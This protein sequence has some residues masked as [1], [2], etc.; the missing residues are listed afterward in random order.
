MNEKTL[1]R[2]QAVRQAGGAPFSPKDT[3]WNW[4]DG[5]VE[6]EGEQA[7]CS[8]GRWRRKDVADR[9]VSWGLLFRDL[10]AYG[11]RLLPTLRADTWYVS[12]LFISLHVFVGSVGH[13][14]TVLE[15]SLPSNY[16]CIGISLVV[17]FFNFFFHLRTWFPFRNRNISGTFLINEERMSCKGL[18]KIM[19]SLFVISRNTLGSLE[20]K[21]TYLIFNT[22]TKILEQNINYLTN[23]LILRKKY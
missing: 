17:I 14:Y 9:A 2:C 12:H 10:Q 15:P 3:N 7:C 19:Q 11:G 21:W 13:R 23:V 22:L 4:S 18:G 6:H 1:T 8:R 5:R 20:A 16:V